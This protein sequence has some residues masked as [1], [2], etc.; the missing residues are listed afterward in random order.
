MT[1]EQRQQAMQQMRSLTNDMAQMMSQMQ[2]VGPQASGAEQRRIMDQMRQM[3]AIMNGMM[4]QFS[5]ATPPTPT[6][7]GR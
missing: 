7:A 4:L 1:P 3:Q 2:N 6:E 5:L